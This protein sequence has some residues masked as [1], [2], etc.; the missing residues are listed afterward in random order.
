MSRGGRYMYFPICPA[1]ARSP[2]GVHERRHLT[3]P[4]TE[5]VFCIPCAYA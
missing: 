2:E 5:G 3:S 1:V 4:L